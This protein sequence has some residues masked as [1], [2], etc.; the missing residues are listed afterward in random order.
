[1]KAKIRTKADSIT[2]LAKTHPI[3]HLTTKLENLENNLISRM[4]EI[5]S[6]KMDGF[7]EIIVELIRA[8]TE[9]ENLIKSVEFVKDVL[10]YI[11]EH[12][13]DSVTSKQASKSLNFNQSYFCRTFKKNF[14]MSF[15]DYLN[16]ERVAYSR[17]L[18]EEGKSITQIALDLGFSSATAYSKCFKQKFNILPSK[19]K[20]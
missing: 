13:F 4:N 2:A 8:K 9:N 5:L 6:E 20:K 18:L 7:D 3:T 11:S 17:K 16:G 14:G 12:L 1:M 10:D 19:Y 15:S